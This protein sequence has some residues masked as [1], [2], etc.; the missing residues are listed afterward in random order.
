MTVHG[1]NGAI[2]LVRPLRRAPN[3]D[4]ESFNLE[5]QAIGLPNLAYF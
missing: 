1:L 5:T 2:R 4:R 3:F